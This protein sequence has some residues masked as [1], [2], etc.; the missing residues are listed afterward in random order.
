V[1]VASGAAGAAV[2]WCFG[3]IRVA[4]HRDRREV[5]YAHRYDSRVCQGNQ[6]RPRLAGRTRAG[7]PC[8]RCSELRKQTATG[9]TPPGTREPPSAWL[10]VD[11]SRGLAV[12]R[13]RGLPECREFGPTPGHRGPLVDG[14]EAELPPAKCS[15]DSGGGCPRS[16]D[17]AA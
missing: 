10:A 11:Q 3:G 14:R 9:P 7:R 16:D 8:R 12:R 13:T 1:A 6:C 17:P 4:E 2:R 5:G 15:A